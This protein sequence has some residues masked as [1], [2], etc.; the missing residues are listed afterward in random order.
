[1]IVVEDEQRLAG[2]A[3]RY[4]AVCGATLVVSWFDVALQLVSQTLQRLKKN[5][6]PLPDFP[7]LMMLLEAEMK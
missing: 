7:A 1:M 4:T 6:P 3:N 2:L 5:P